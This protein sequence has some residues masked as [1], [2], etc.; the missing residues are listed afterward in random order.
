MALADEL[1]MRPLIAHCRLGLAQLSRS[2]GD[3]E[4]A[5]DHLATATGMYHEMAMPYWL[6]R[7][8]ALHDSSFSG[9]EPF[10]CP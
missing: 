3:V 2:M 7:A 5:R 4:A 1:G 6:R 9:G 8:E 10:V